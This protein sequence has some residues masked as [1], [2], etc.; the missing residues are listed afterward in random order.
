MACEME[1]EKDQREL[2]LASISQADRLTALI[3]ASLS[4]PQ[5]QQQPLE[6]PVPETPPPPYTLEPEPLRI[7]EEGELEGATAAA[8]GGDTRQEEGSE[9]KPSRPNSGEGLTKGLTVTLSAQQLLA[10]ST[11]LNEQLTQLLVSTQLEPHVG[12]STNLAVRA[13]VH[14]F[15]V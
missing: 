12:L 9:G 1:G 13:G 7:V 2:L 10:I 4:V 11:K 3:N 15:G 8:G 5:H 6:V 14:M